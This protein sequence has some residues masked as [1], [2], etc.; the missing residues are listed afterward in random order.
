MLKKEESKFVDSDR[1]EGISSISAL[2]KGIESGVNTRRIIRILYDQEKENQKK[3]ELSFLRAKAK[4]HSFLVESTSADVIDQL[5]L[6][7]THGGLIAE[8]TPRQIPL[9]SIDEISENGVYFIL[10]G[11]EDP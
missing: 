6:G 11:V 2:I 4:Q 3:R 10:E 1:L 9:L 8:C 5:T 7:N